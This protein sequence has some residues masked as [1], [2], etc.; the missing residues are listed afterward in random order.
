MSPYQ[1]LFGR[2]RSVPGLPYTPERECESASQ[3][4]RRMEWVDETISK[5]INTEHAK[6][7][8]C[9]NRSRKTREPFQEGEKVWVRKSP[10]LSSSSTLDTRWRGPMRVVQRRGESSY[11][12][13]DS[14][15]KFHDVHMEQ[16]QRYIDDENIQSPPVSMEEPLRPMKKGDIIGHRIGEPGEDEF[17]VQWWDQP[18]SE[19]SWLKCSTM[20]QEGLEVP[21]LEFCELR[22]WYPT[23]YHSH[24][25]GE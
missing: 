13:V 1:I 8:E 24:D 23:M 14:Q 22:G 16:L 17:L 6:D 15:G 4:I 2:D 5:R 19:A 11:Q 20:L 3:F 9:A 12:V 7:M 21:T 25:A 10:S 18:P